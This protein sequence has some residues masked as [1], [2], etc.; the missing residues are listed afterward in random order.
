MRPL[1]NARTH[2]FGLG[3]NESGS[4]S[5][6]IFQRIPR[7]EP[8]R[9]SGSMDD[10]TGH[11]WRSIKMKLARESICFRFI[12][13]CS[14]G[15][16]G[17]DVARMW[18][19]VKHGAVFRLR[20][21]IGIVFRSLLMWLAKLLAKPLSREYVLRMFYDVVWCVGKLLLRFAT[22]GIVGCMSRQPDDSIFACYGLITSV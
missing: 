10:N 14:V 7:F 12:V 15:V 18:C 2:Y 4:S 11:G 1:F 16:R 8:S 13:C 6:I 22:C 5:C 3:H 20:Q 17:I 21:R 19:I 9:E